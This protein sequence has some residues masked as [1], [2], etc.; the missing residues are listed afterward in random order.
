MLT[1]GWVGANGWKAYVD[2]YYKDGL[3]VGAQEAILV[4]KSM[5]CDEVSSPCNIV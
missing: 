1:L 2:K 4:A 3:P 5:E